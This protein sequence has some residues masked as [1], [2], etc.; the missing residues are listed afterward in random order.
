M[1]TSS[2]LPTVRDMGRFALPLGSKLVGGALG[3]KR[4]VRWAHTSGV[5]S[6]LFPTIS[7]DE[8]ALLDLPLIQ[9]T[10]PTL[11]LARAVRELGRLR[12][13]AI[14]VKGDVNHAAEREASRGNMPLFVLPSQADVGRVAR[15]IRR[16]IS[17]REAQEEAQAAALYRLL[18]Q[19]VAMGKGLSGLV[20]Q[21]HDLSAHAV[22]VSD[23]NGNTLARAGVVPPQSVEKKKILYVD[24]SP[25]AILTMYDAPAMLDSFSQLA[26][27]QG[28]AALTLELVKLEAVEAAKVGVYGDFVVSLLA[29]EEDSRLRARARA[30]TYAL[31]GAQWAILAVVD[32]NQVSEETLKHWM[33]RIQAHAERL[34]WQV[35]LHL[36]EVIMPSIEHARQATFILAGGPKR[37][38][39]THRAF[40]DY[41]LQTWSDASPLS[42]AVADVGERLSGLKDTLTQARDALSLG[43]RLFGAG[44]QHL[45][46]EMGLYR[47]LRHLQGT[48]DLN[49][50]VDQTLSELQTYD[51]QHETELVETL[52]TLLD[53]GGN[54]SA[55]AKAMHL[56]RNSLIYRIERIRDISGFD[57]TKPDDSFALKLAL[58][59]APLR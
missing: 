55:T 48:D 4:M 44:H 23:L 39:S 41:L 10:N 6:P 38:E 28:A 1:T 26:L 16:L 31:D 33:E 49:Q 32:A 9:A 50:F 59:L 56:H 54:V 37:W 5:M 2:I 8:V 35:R 57:P 42:L 12:L 45:H 20:N 17:D 27:E 43:L 46:R 29:G 7:A 15:A 14:V 40:L 21:L 25:V 47:L 30:A 53:H 19:G 13:A 34:G 24:E 11:T 36:S 52:R 51:Q 58:M 3:V 18:S 22:R